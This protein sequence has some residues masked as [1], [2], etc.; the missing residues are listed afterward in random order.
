MNGYQNNH[1]PPMQS[2]KR[3]NPA[4]IVP[5]RKRLKRT[6]DSDDS[7]DEVRQESEKVYDR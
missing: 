7:E 2:L 4:T 5:K 1:S 3:E 6:A